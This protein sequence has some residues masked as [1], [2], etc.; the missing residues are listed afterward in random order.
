MQQVDSDSDFKFIAHILNMHSL[1]MLIQIR[2]QQL[3]TCPGAA[4]GVPR[5]VPHRQRMEEWVDRELQAIL[6]TADVALV[7]MFVLG[8]L[9]A[10]QEQPCGR[11]QLPGH[12]VPPV[13]ALRPFLADQAEHFWH[14]LRSVLCFNAILPRRMTWTRPMHQGRV[15]CANRLCRLCHLP[16]FMVV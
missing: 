3:L 7:R 6:G 9:L 12:R 1:P 14:E 11:A 2:G 15:A 16:R 13:E 10:E 5:A 4:P 8:V